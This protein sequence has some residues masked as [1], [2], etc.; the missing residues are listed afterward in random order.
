MTKF[1]D[2]LFDV[3]HFLLAV[4]ML[5]FIVGGLQNALGNPIEGLLRMVLGVQLV[6]LAKM[7]GTS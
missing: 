7:K 2:W 4:G 3:N 1:V 5:I 6:M